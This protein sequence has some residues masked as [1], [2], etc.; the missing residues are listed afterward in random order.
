[1]WQKTFPSEV[2]SHHQRI[3]MKE[4][5]QFDALNLKSSEGLATNC[6]QCFGP[7]PS[8]NQSNASC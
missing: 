7:G 1:E 4:K 3:Q 5:L 2:Y 8:N 6:P